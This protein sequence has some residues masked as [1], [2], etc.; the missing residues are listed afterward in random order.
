M[1]ENRNI[2]LESG[3]NELEFV[4]FCVNDL[5]CGVNVAKVREII[6]KPALRSIVGSPASVAGMIN[7]RDNV[8]PVI[9]LCQILGQQA[10]E[11]ANQVLIL[12]FNRV[13]IGVL[14]NSVS[15]IYRISWKQ[16][17][18]PSLA[19]SGAYITGL[20]KMDGRI[21]LILDFER[22]LAELYQEGAVMALDLK[23][24]VSEKGKDRKILV[25]DDSS[26]IR[27]QICSTL[28]RA[29][30]II[31]EAANGEEAWNYIDKK[32]AAGQLDI[33]AVIT[34]VE[35]PKMDGLHLVT[36]VRS[37]TELARLP[38][39]V[40]SSLASEDNIRKWK[41]LEIN[42]VLTKPDLPKLV[43]ILK[44]CFELDN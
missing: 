23:E 43:D 2:L 21:I 4:E 19:A 6:R 3:T 7:L 31:E 18:A 29:G 38:V 11:A 34:D 32:S 10:E 28:R 20:V 12:E 24:P 17:E 41:Q 14:V 39:F 27:A 15:R 22:I 5:Y 42:G 25:V 30:Y 1:E 16:V 9:D 44:G 33:D 26:F 35:M 13:M 8:L 36:L 37:K 40:F